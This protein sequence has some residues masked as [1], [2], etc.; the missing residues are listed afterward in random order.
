MIFQEGISAISAKVK[1]VEFRRIETM[2]VETNKKGDYL[3][4]PQLIVIPAVSVGEEGER[5]CL[6][7]R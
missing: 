7:C 4:A 3:E 1:M 5:A 2:G 6:M